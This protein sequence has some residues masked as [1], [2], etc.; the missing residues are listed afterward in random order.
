MAWVALS[1]LRKRGCNNMTTRSKTGPKEPIAEPAKQ[2]RP[3]VKPA[4]QHEKVFET[5]ALSCGKVAG[6]Q[7]T[8]RNNR[9][10]S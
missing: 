3:Y 7:E 5:M 8:C 4:F 6:T 10:A 1:K 9:K 2:K